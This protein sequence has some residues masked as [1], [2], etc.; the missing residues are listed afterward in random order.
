[1]SDRWWPHNREPQTRGKW[2]GVGAG[3]MDQGIRS[4]VPGP[5]WPFTTTYCC[6][7][8]ESVPPC[9]FPGLLHAGSAHKFI[10]AN[11]HTYKINKSWGGGLPWA[12]SNWREQEAK[13]C[14]STPQKGRINNSR[15]RVCLGKGRGLQVS[16]V[17]NNSIWKPT[18]D[19]LNNSQPFSSATPLSFKK[20]FQLQVCQ[21]WATVL[22]FS[23]L[24]EV[25]R[26]KGDKQAY[27]YEGPWESFHHWWDFLVAANL[28]LLTV[29]GTVSYLATQSA[30]PHNL[31][32]C[33]CR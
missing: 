3:E 27:V 7:S 18:P 24:P 22:C 21:P 33:F 2:H 6:S 26:N 32:Q 11:T 17:T 25:S 13:I 31:L 10:Q 29:H 8:R 14:F 28:S 1:M 30:S 15:W 19:F 12:L 5:T 23:G 16:L 20:G 9:G 4:F